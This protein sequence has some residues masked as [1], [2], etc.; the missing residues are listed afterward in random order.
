MALATVGCVCLVIKGAHRANFRLR[1]KAWV[2]RSFSFA[3]MRFLV[4]LIVLYCC[5][6]DRHATSVKI[7]ITF[8]EKKFGYLD[9]CV[10]Q[11]VLRVRLPPI[12]KNFI[13]VVP[14]IV[15]L[16]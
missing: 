13:F 12:L 16:G 15:I 7:M 8:I 6:S 4:V 1:E 9:T 10:Q 3:V 5:S 11:N 2:L 14:C